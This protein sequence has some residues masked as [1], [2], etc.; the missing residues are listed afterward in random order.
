MAGPENSVVYLPLKTLHPRSQLIF[1][2]DWSLVLSLFVTA[3]SLLPAP[4]S[5][6]CP[7]WLSHGS[8]SVSGSSLSPPSPS[9]QNLAGC[10]ATPRVISPFPGPELL[11]PE[12]L[13]SSWSLGGAERSRQSVNQDRGMARAGGAWLERSSGAGTGVNWRVRSSKRQEEGHRASE[14]PLELGGG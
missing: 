5:S 14:P 1:L 2:L 8:A 13:V 4:L 7:E 3:L 10:R 11:A 6:T 12:Q 9:P